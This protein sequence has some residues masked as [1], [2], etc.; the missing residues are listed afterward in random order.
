MDEISNR[1]FTVESLTIAGKIISVTS[2]PDPMVRGG[3]ASITVNLRNTGNMVWPTAK[4]TVKIYKPDGKLYGTYNLSIENLPP[5][6][7]SSFSIKVKVAPTAPSG[8]YNSEI[9]LA[10]G[11]EQVDMYKGTI[12]VA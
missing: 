6:V 7:D 8:T 10:S 3:T 11:A 1:P 9:S 2:S 12:Q 5:N 4:I